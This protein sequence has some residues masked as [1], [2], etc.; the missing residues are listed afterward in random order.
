[1]FRASRFA[2]ALLLLAPVAAASQA[3]GNTATRA[4][5]KGTYDVVKTYLTKAVAQVGEEHY[6]YKPTPEV[7]SMGE[8]FGHI[9]NANFMICAMAKGEKSPSAANFE[10]VT[11]KAEMQK[12]IADSFAYCDAAWTAVE[13]EKGTEA[14]D[15]FG[16]KHTRASAMA[17]NSAHD[18]EH[19]GNLVTYMRLRGMVPPSSQ[20]GGGN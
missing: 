2:A 12:A 14:V 16:M 11:T 5:L 17:F 1:M 20:R 4:G 19:Y 3:Q 10:K 18:W 6:S 15:I 13:G 9:A 7:R 8:L